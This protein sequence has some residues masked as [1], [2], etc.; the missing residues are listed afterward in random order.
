MHR[1]YIKIFRRLKDSDLWLEEP[2]TRGQAW[3]D[4]IMLANHKDGHIRKRGVKIEIKRG[5]CGYSEL[6]LAERWRWSR[7]KV[8]R[9]LIE[10]ETIQQIIQ[11]KTR[12]TTL[13]TI[14][15]YNEYQAN[16]TTDDTTDN[17]T[18]GQQ[19]DINNNDNNDKKKRYVSYPAEFEKFWAEYPNRKCGK[20]NTFKSWKRLNGD[21]PEIDTLLK[22]LD[23]HKKSTDWQKNNGQFIPMATTWLNQRR[24][25]AEVENPEQ[26]TK[27]AY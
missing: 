27:W 5:Q 11:Q 25:D 15:N 1:G 26:K 7:G 22:I 12:L 9:F 2:F 13:I 6:A 3:V 4:L 23:A 21:K 16:K 14:I 19:T 17:T 18:D 8:N 10:L 20:T 24:W